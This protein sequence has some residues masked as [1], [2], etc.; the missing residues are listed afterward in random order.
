MSQCEVHQKWGSKSKPAPIAGD[1]AAFKFQDLIIFMFMFIS[2]FIFI[3]IHLF[4]PFIYSNIKSMPKNHHVT[5]GDYI[6]SLFI[7]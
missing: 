1:V 2:M 7:L 5:N 6:S 4:I 3:V